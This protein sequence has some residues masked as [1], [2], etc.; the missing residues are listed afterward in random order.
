MT[1]AD[2]EPDTAYGDF[3]LRRFLAMDVSSPGAGA[4]SATI[5]VGSAHLNPNGVVHGAVLFALLDTAMGSAAMSVLPDG[6]YCTS[7]DLQT[8]FIRPAVAG[9]LTATVDVV[10]AGR[11]VIHLDGQVRDADDRLIATGSG[12]FTTFTL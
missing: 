9:S 10:K 4:A 3:P 5:A 7:V 11:H 8:R 1:D 12:T 6:T 2:A